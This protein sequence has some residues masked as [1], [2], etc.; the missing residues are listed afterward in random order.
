[1]DINHATRRSR[2]KPFDIVKP[3][4]ALKRT[5]GFEWIIMCEDCLAHRAPFWSK[6]DSCVPRVELQTKG[7]LVCTRTV[8]GPMY[9]LKFRVLPS[10]CFFCA[11][12]W[13]N[14]DDSDLKD[15]E[16]ASGKQGLQSEWR[17]CE[18]E[19]G[20]ESSVKSFGQAQGMSHR[21]ICEA[22]GDKTKVK[23]IWGSMHSYHA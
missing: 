22:K 17:D 10:L 14:D 1:M 5:P 13:Q 20:I 3:H 9:V 12:H 19:F 7:Q 18:D 21:A 4:V 8:P 16:T 15:G 23:S 6:R 11:R 2:L